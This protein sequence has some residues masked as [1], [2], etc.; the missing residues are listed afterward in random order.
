M[1]KWR[2][3]FY[4]ISGE[5]LVQYS[6]DS[7]KLSLVGGAAAPSVARP[8]VVAADAVARRISRRCVRVPRCL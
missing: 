8:V 4:V 1:G 2:K 6:D 5:S 3:R 7:L